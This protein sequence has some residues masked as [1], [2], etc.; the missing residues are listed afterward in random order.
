M[1]CSLHSANSERQPAKTHP[2]KSLLPPYPDLFQTFFKRKLYF[3]LSPDWKALREKVSLFPNMFLSTPDPS[4]SLETWPQ[5]VR[6]E[7]RA[8]VRTT[9]QE[10]EG[11]HPYLASFVTVTTKAPLYHRGGLFVWPSAGN[12]TRKCGVKNSPSWN[13]SR[14]QTLIFVATFLHL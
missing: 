14:F 11:I 8:Y 13:I 7:S 2:K 10:R 6:D 1:C 12:G 3:C 9:D 4:L 5:Y